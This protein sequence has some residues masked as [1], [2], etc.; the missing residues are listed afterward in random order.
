MNSTPPQD[1]A[2]AVLHQVLTDS[3]LTWEQP[4]PFA[5]VVTLPGE[6]KLATPC[7]FV[8]GPHTVSINAF[9]ARKPDENHEEVYRR[10]LQ[11][12]PRLSGIAFALD[13]LGDI[14]LV[15]R[16]PTNGL[17]AELVDSLMGSVAVAADGMFDR[18]LATGFESS[19]RKE[20]QWRQAQGEPT[21]NLEPFRHLLHLE[22]EE[23]PDQA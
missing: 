6:H 23:G 8:V 22:A 18:I 12:N 21:D 16:V 7:A 14:Y 2:A 9:V 5:F 20:W 1:R 11:Q 13:R 15:G 10:I 19:I 3:E 4:E 17:T